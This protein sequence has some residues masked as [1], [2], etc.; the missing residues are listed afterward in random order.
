MNSEQRINRIMG[1]HRPGS[2]AEEENQTKSKP[3]DSDILNPL[4]V[5]SVSKRVVLGDSVDGGV[6]DYQP[7]GG[8]D[9]REP[10]WET[11]W[12]H[13]LKHQS[14]VARMELSFGSGTEVT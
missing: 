2:G 7:S 10:S 4:G 14:A 8:A 6:T 1:F 9:I 5:P 12:T 11:N 13:S 3:L